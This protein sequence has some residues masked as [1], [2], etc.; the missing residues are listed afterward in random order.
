MPPLAHWRP[1]MP[2]DSKPNPKDGSDD[3]E[4]GYGKPPKHSQFK[5]GQSGN[6]KGRPKNSRNL[7]T[8][9]KEEMAEKIDVRENGRLKKLS[10]QRAML[11]ALSNKALTGDPRTAQLLI[12]MLEQLLPD[13][14]DESEARALGSDDEE[15]L[16]LFRKNELEGEKIRN[17]RENE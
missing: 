17:A 8:D 15:I 10:K 1:L 6:R 13:E 11:K 16:K 14:P 9:L 3:Y 12:N 4:V 7:K 2:N 5:Q